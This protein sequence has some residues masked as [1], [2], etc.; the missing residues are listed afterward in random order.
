MCTKRMGTRMNRA[1]AL[2]LAVAMILSLIPAAFAGQEDGY[3]DPAEHWY[4]SAN[5]TNELDI[6]AVVTQESWL[7]HICGKQTPF[8]TW[9]T[10]EYTRDGV[11]SVAHGIAYS[12]GASLSGVMGT[13]MWGKPGV[14]ATYTGYHWGKSVCN[15][16]GTF[17]ANRGADDYGFKKNIYQLYSC[18]AEFTENLPTT[19]TVEYV[20]GTYHR[21]TTVTGN[22]CE[23]CYGTHKTTSSVLENHSK[24]IETIPQPANGR[25]ATIEKCTQCDYTASSYTAAKAVVASYYGVVDGQP[26]T[27]TVTDLS[28]SGVGV[29]IRY[30][31]SADSCTLTSAPNYTD[32]GQYTVYYEITYT[33]KGK[34]MTENGVAYVWLRD[35]NVSDDG[36]CACGCGD[37]DCGC[38]GPD[39]DGCSGNKCNC[40]KPGCSGSTCTG[41]SCGGCG[42][43][44]CGSCSG[45]NPG[46]A[47]GNHNFQFLE[48]V[49]PGCLTLGYTRY[50]CT[51]CVT[52]QRS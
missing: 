44:T 25:F 30:G 11:S 39:K 49:D 19:R 32:E 9:R 28:E 24:T 48:K 5:R 21:V 29:T 33:Y 15:I 51:D 38:M 22:Y 36:H 26:H 8:T 14:N 17:N 1:M 37:P 16:C 13:I 50:L 34:S 46:C 10:P 42:G 27:I 40:G 6:N 18:D 3:H 12:D 4:D 35:E 31:N 47:E 43:S 45:K 20:D 52:I 2:L 7:C 41:G 23:H